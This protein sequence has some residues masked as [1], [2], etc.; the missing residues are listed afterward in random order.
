MTNI[1]FAVKNGSVTINCN[2]VAG[3]WEEENPA[4]CTKPGT[5][6]QKCTKCGTVLN[7]RDTNALGH[8]F[9]EI[10]ETVNISRLYPIKE[11]KKR[12]LLLSASTQKPVISTPWVHSWESD[13]TID[14]EATCTEDGS[15]SIH[16]SRCDAVKDS[17]VIP[18]GHKYGGW[19]CG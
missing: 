15:Q 10:G 5:E 13:Y 16:C 8:E 12:N 1:T 18:K 7:R 3:A 4:S 2:H 11:A 9:W 19:S 14:K 6:V 17:Q